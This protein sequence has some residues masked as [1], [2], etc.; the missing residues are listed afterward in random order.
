MTT[1]KIRL[2]GV[3]IAVRDGGSSLSPLSVYPKKSADEPKEPATINEG[4][5]LLPIK[6]EP[7]TDEPQ[8]RKHLSVESHKQHTKKRKRP[9]PTTN[10]ENQSNNIPFRL[11]H[12]SKKKKKAK[13]YLF[14]V[15][16]LCEAQDNVFIHCNR[17]KSVQQLGKQYCLVHMPSNKIPLNFKVE[18][19]PEMKPPADELEHYERAKYKWTQK[20]YSRLHTLMD[21][22]AQSTPPID[23]FD[24]WEMKGES[25]DDVSEEHD[26]W[27][28]K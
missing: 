14:P 6:V 25:E 27:E 7:D 17:C 21:H 11:P 13:R 19:T 23:P 16:C 24:R 28:L 3:D 4:H 10:K 20:I 2:F 18:T 9:L 5:A 1:T 15:K 12:G 26:R 8:D 22:P